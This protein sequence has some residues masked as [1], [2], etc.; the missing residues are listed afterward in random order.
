MSSTMETHMLL[1]KGEVEKRLTWRDLA[2]HAWKQKANQCKFEGPV[3]TEC[4]YETC[5][6]VLFMSE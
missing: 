1:T 5:P 6:F 4:K 2:I 3:C